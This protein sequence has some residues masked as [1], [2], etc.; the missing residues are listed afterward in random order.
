MS[1]LISEEQG[2]RPIWDNLLS[3]VNGIDCF[4]VF[5]HKALKDVQQPRRRMTHRA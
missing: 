2:R 1:M 5:E 4:S 3:S